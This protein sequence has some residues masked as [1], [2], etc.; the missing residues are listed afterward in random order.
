MCRVT[1]QVFGQVLD[2]G[3]GV[4][5]PSTDDSRHNFFGS[6]NQLVLHL[7]RLGAINRIFNSGDK[8]DSQV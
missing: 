5:P 3:I 6:I 1:E 7:T 2:D 8:H 4:G